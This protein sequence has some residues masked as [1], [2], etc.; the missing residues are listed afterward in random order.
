MARPL[1]GVADLV[2]WHD[3][4]VNLG[5]APNQFTD[6]I[7]SAHSGRIDKKGHEFRRLVDEDHRVVKEIGMVVCPFR[8][9]APGPQAAGA[10]DS[11]GVAGIVWRDD[12]LAGESAAGEDK[13]GEGGEDGFHGFVV[14]FVAIVESFGI[15]LLVLFFAKSFTRDLRTR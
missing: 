13:E 2:G 5:A 3:R 4:L 10:R 6:I 9:G 1:V 11:G 8:S 15:L 12:S 14:V 7:W